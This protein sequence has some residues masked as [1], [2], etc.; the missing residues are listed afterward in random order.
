MTT[1]RSLRQ[2]PAAERFLVLAD[3]IG[4]VIGDPNAQ[5]TTDRKATVASVVE[6]VQQGVHVGESAKA[7]TLLVRGLTDRLVKSLVTP[8]ELISARHRLGAK[9]GLRASDYDVRF[10]KNFD[11]LFGARGVTQRIV[12]HAMAQLIS[13][14]HFPVLVNKDGTYKGTPS[15]LVGKSVAENTLVLIL[16]TRNEDV[17][18]VG[19]AWLVPSEDGYDARSVW[20]SFLSTYGV[21]VSVLGRPPERFIESLTL[22]QA[23]HGLPASILTGMLAD[24]RL[25]SIQPIARAYMRAWARLDGDGTLEIRAAFAIDNDRYDR[26]HPR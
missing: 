10:A 9:G 22:T 19:S 24:G 4:S 16:A 25:L 13:L 5:L 11:A 14:H 21:D 7:E 20:D 23:D 12:M 26:D 15:V 3:A 1:L 6:E 8:Q 2:I 17:L 18:E